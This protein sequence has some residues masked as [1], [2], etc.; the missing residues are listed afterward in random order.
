MKFLIRADG[1]TT[2]GGGHVM[3][4]LTL[5]Q[6]ARRRGHDAAFVMAQKPSSMLH[7]VAGL[8]YTVFPI[9]PDLQAP[10]ENSE[11]VHAKWLPTS[12]RADADITIAAAQKFQPD[13]IV[14]DHYGLDARWVRHIREQTNGVRFLAIDDLD[15]RAIAS[16]LV[17]DQTRVTRTA[18]TQTA[19]AYLTGA[20]FALLRPEFAEL[21][22]TAI[23]NRSAKV[24]RV[25][26][27]PGMVDGAHLAPL[28]INAL[29]EYPDVAIDVVMGSE[30]QTISEVQELL[31][32]RKNA[33][34]HLDAQNMAELISSADL[35]IGAGGMTSWERCCLG[36]PAVAICTADNQSEVLNGLQAQGALLSLTLAQARDPDTMKRT[37]A[38]AFEQRASLSKAAANLCDGRGTGRVVDALEGVLRK[39]TAQDAQ[40]LFDW[41]NQQ[42]I[43][44]VS[45][46]TSELVWENHVKWLN[47]ILQEDTG[48]WLIYREGKRDL[49]H[50]NARLRGENTWH[51]G[52]YIGANDAPRGAGQRML[53]LFIERLFSLPDTAAIT[54]DVRKDNAVSIALHQRL[55]FTQTESQSP[56]ALAF[57]LDRCDVNLVGID[58]H[59]TQGDSTDAS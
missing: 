57:R 47:S 6:E 34:L 54:A 21:R 12:W 44:E 33:Q 17:L 10:R 56:D 32:K 29:T 30:S 39:V 46:D 13:W 38:Q 18:R 26:I 25:L 51:W 11:P 7:R 27:A 37:L 9:T 58:P 16:E 42:R 40:L 49:G 43:R 2:I 14:W 3:R 35:C 8:G 53:A 1:D 55:G 19:D 45:L 23:A 4:C 20:S 52:F 22:E 28:A 50:V 48:Q 59:S 15:D 41:R 5:A 31:A 36:L 24:S